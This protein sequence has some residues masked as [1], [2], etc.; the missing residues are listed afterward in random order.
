MTKKQDKEKLEE[1]FIE[2]IFKRAVSERASDIHIEPLMKS[3]FIRFRI[4]G[5]LQERWQKPLYKLEPL[6][7]KIKA[8]ANLDIIN[9]PI[10]QEGHFEFNIKLPERT[11]ESKQKQDKNESGIPRENNEKE[12]ILDVR[13]SIFRTINGEAAVLRLLN[14]SE[15]LISLKDLGMDQKSFLT[16]KKL[17][18]KIY[19]MVLITGPSG[20]GKT[21]TLYSILRELQGIDKNIITLEDPV[22][23]RFENIRQN[24][25]KPEQGFTFAVAMRSVLRQ[26]PDVIMVGEIRDPETAEHAVRAS[27]TGRSV[28][29]TVH[30]NTTI[31][32]IAR[33]IDMNVERSL[34]AYAINGVISQRLVRKICPLCKINYIPD[35]EILRYF[36]LE[37]EKHQFIKGE[38]CDAC[39]NTGY[40]GRTGIFEV[41]EFDDK[42]RA[43]V[44]EKA[45]MNVLQA[46]AEKEGLKTLKQDAVEKVLLGITTLEEATKVV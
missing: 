25:M 26:D 20:S 46:H 10:P 22:E 42:L 3:M 11:K 21:T 23:L 45:P 44:I 8:L 24:Q 33:L 30:S 9:R 40:H 36:N 2:T 35:L 16:V 38:G 41:L 12:R 17:I 1:D 19:G 14:R 29:S 13:V 5:I 28:C 31:G 4:D 32:T 43:L 27:L 37:E 15:M 7:N 34:I 6:I 39:N 18:S